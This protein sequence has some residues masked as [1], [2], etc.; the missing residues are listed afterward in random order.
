MAT[1]DDER[2]IAGGGH[3]LRPEGHWN[4][5]ENRYVPSSWER[6]QAYYRGQYVD[7][8]GSWR[9]LYPAAPSCPPEPPAA[10]YLARILWILSVV[11]GYALVFRTTQV[12][13][14]HTWRDPSYW[15]AI[16][17]VLG[18]AVPLVTYMFAG[19]KRLGLQLALSVSP[20]AGVV[21]AL[22]Y[23]AGSDFL[24]KVLSL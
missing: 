16:A 18:T 22:A 12:I 3:T 8:D 4:T 7:K 9:D 21:P 24:P 6:E 10:Y 20:L 11:C 5:A 13:P 1:T 2:G 17:V 15:F 14:P 19:T 23:E